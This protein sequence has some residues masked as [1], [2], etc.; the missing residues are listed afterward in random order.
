[1]DGFRT[2]LAL[3]GRWIR[4]IPL[5]PAHAGALRVAARD[6]HI[7]KFMLNGP[8]SQFEEMNA[9]IALLL[10]RH[11]VGT[12][13]PFTTILRASGRVVGMTRYLN[14][15]RTNRSVEVGGTWLDSALWKSPINTESKYLL[16]RHAFESEQV[17]RVS[18]QTDRRNERSQRAIERL[19]AV[20]EAEFRDDKLLRDGTFRT[21]VVYG[22]LIS[23][24]PTV[25]AGLEAK[26][27][28]NWESP[29]EL[30]TEGSSTSFP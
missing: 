22:V 1:M 27:A 28:V 4:L 18:L 26:L 10:E 5:E 20:R 19:G 24:W 3:D 12:D 23:E 15:D 2:P 14:I 25:K 6:P 13:L 16:F 9:L 7:G 8:S 17:H 30:P 21:S 11:R 29:P